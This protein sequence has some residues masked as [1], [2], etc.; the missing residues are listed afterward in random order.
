MGSGE[1]EREAWA[2][3]VV[4][5]EGKCLEVSG[6]KSVEAVGVERKPDAGGAAVWSLGD[7][8]YEA[9]LWRR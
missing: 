9:V 5:R 8:A 4:N 2:Q 6:D 7:S 1:V 3:P